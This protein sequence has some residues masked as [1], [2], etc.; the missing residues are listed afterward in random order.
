MTARESL[1][2]TV[3]ATF[4]LVAGIVTAPIVAVAW[5]FAFAWWIWNEADGDDDPLGPVDGPGGRQEDADR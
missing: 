3:L 5:P 1:R 4:G 2:R